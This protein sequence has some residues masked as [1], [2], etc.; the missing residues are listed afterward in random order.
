MA[1]QIVDQA[2]RHIRLA[3]QAAGRDDW[4]AVR[5]HAELLA[6]VLGVPAPVCPSPPWF[7]FDQAQPPKKE[8]IIALRFIELAG[9]I[10]P[11]FDVRIGDGGDFEPDE[12]HWWTNALPNIRPFL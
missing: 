11:E 10:S 6:G 9:G 8:Q 1:E 2:R 7:R 3:S 5:D 4:G 12:W